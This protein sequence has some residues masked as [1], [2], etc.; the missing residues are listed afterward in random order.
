[1]AQYS[2]SELIQK[3]EMVTDRRN[4]HNKEREVN[5]SASDF[6]EHF[7]NPNPYPKS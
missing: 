2:I 3:N 6:G 4:N 5:N 7:S 1:V